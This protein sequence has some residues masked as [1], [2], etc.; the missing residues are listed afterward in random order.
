MRSLEPV[1]IVRVSLQK[2]MNRMVMLLGMA[3]GEG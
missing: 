2:S 1:S 3:Q